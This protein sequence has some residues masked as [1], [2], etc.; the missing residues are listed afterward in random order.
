[1]LF[2]LDWTET[3]IPEDRDDD[4]RLPDHQLYT[5]QGEAAEKSN[6]VKMFL[7]NL[8]GVAVRMSHS[9]LGWWR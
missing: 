5:L 8:T 6:P 3:D 2:L 4:K 7:Y 1:M 9:I